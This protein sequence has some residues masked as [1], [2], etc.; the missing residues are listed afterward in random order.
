MSVNCNQKTSEYLNGT[1]S[2]VD[3]M[4]VDCNQEPSEYLNATTS[5]VDKMNVDSSKKFIK[6]KQERHTDEN[7]EPSLKRLRRSAC[8]EARQKAKMIPL[9]NE[10]KN[11]ELFK[12][13]LD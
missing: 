4:S 5:Q 2:Q 6:S 13:G 8:I 1:K 10:M 12:Q 9:L 11:Q 3:K 7:I